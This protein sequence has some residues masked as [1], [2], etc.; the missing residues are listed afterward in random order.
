M[1]YDKIGLSTY[2]GFLILNPLLQDPPK[3]IRIVA[4]VPFFR[5]FHGNNLEYRFYIIIP[6]EAK[7]N[8]MDYFQKLKSQNIIVHFE[9][10]KYVSYKMVLQF[11]SR[12][13]KSTLVRNIFPFNSS[14]WKFSRARKTPMQKSLLKIFKFEYTTRCEG[15]HARNFRWTPLHLYLAFNRQKLFK[16][17]FHYENPSKFFQFVQQ[18]IKSFGRSIDFNFSA[19][20][21]EKVTDCSKTRDYFNKMASVLHYNLKNDGNDLH[22]ERMWKEYL[23]IQDAFT[24]KHNFSKSTLQ[25]TLIQLINSQILIENRQMQLL[26][27]I[28]WFWDSVYIHVESPQRIPLLESSLMIY[29]LERFRTDEGNLVYRYQIAIPV[30]YWT[31]FCQVFFNDLDCNFLCPFQPVGYE[32]SEDLVFYYNYTTQSW[33]LEKFDLQSVHSNFPLNNTRTIPN[34]LPNFNPHLTPQRRVTD[35]EKM[36]NFSQ[37]IANTQRFTTI[38]DR[39]MKSKEEYLKFFKI[40]IE[41]KPMSEK[42]MKNYLKV[43]FSLDFNQIYQIIQNINFHVVPLPQYRNMRKVVVI[44]Q[45]HSFPCHPDV[46]LTDPL[47]SGLFCHGLLSVSISRGTSNGF[48]LL[49]YE[50]STAILENP[51]SQINQVIA[52]INQNY[53]L[54][55]RFLVSHHE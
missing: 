10:L 17:L 16:S 48:L 42:S 25:N 34:S 21:I 32:N 6:K 11:N 9:I 29:I 46:L 37:M 38:T 55:L 39:L 27:I 28:Q 41:N 4:K 54:Q 19:R 12:V 35:R 53:H 1:Q 36:H 47:L 31:S 51:K 33:N 2:F 8:V 52:K 49:E 18:N 15:E 30:I 23:F 3:I 24:N 50:L 14:D 5:M 26:D 22:W 13:S 43:H 20:E 40:W 7:L 45:E 44:L